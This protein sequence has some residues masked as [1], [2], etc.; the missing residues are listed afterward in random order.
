MG[1]TPAEAALLSHLSG[2]K[3]PKFLIPIYKKAGAKYHI[4]WPVL[5][6]I[7]SIETD[8]GRDLKVSPAGAEGWMQFMPSTWARYGVAVDHSG[9]ANPYNPADAI[10]S[11]ARYLAASGGA[12]HIRRAVLAYNHAQWYVNQVMWRAAV[13]NSLAGGRAA[14]G[15]ANPFRGGWIPNRLDMGYDGTFA[16]LLAAPFS[17]TITFAARSFSNWGGYVQ[18]RADHPIKGLPTRTFYFAEGLS[19]LFRA[20]THV[21]AGTPIAVAAPSPWGDAYNTTGRGQG[22]IEWGLAESGPTGAPTDPLAETGIQNP[23]RMV[24]AFAIWAVEH[25]GVAPPASTDHAGFS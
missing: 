5:A 17:G 11:A 21:H 24:K 25:L 14:P 12:K 9:P 10:F 20:G 3:P 7:N 18:L 6:A 2:L 23:A 4:P 22:Q 13:I 16:H 19:P 8:Y 15:F 1:L